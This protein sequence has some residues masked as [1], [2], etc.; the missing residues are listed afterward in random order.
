MPLTYS[1]RAQKGLDRRSKL[2]NKNYHCGTGFNGHFTSQIIQI[3]NKCI[4]SAQHQQS[5][6]K[7]KI[8]PIVRYYFIKKFKILRVT[9]QPGKEQPEPLY[10]NGGRERL[11]NHCKT[12]SFFK[13]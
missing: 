6:K 2:A 10:I 5:L 4:K 13:S 1:P 11:Y 3:I 7:C 9:K 12:G 8:K